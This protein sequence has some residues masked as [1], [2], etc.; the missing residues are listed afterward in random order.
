MPSWERTCARRGAAWRGVAW[1]AGHAV[2]VICIAGRCARRLHWPVPC[3]AAA[4][5]AARPWPGPDN[6]PPAPPRPAPP[7]PPPPMET[8]MRNRMACMRCGGRCA[9]VLLRIDSDRL[10]CLRHHAR[11]HHHHHHYSY[12]N[13]RRHARTRC[14]APRSASPRP[15]IKRA[16][17][18]SRLAAD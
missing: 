11:Y 2:K 15:H 3:P 9:V 14:A 1:R 7:F 13:R 10:V 12:R 5:A 18:A 8:Y 6:G 17:A 4:A 16:A